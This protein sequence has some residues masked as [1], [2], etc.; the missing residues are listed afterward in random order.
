MKKRFSHFEMIAQRLV[1]GSFG[2]LFGE[3]L[4]PQDIGSRLA[5]AM[6]D[7][8]E[9]GQ[10]ADTYRIMLNPADQQSL[11]RRDPELAK[12]LSAYLVQLAQQAN[13]TLLQQPTVELIPDPML[14]RQAIRVETEQSHATGGSTQYQPRN[15]DDQALNLLK[16]VD[17]FLIVEGK[18]HVPLN[19]PIMTV[20]RRTDNDIVVNNAAVSRQH[21]QIRWRYGRFVI[22]DLGSRGG[23]AVNGQTI[24]E[25]VL[26]A[27]D[28]ITLS[29]VPLI[30]GEEV[31]RSEEVR[32]PADPGGQ[33]ET[34]IT[35]PR[36][37]V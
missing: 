29:G 13:L 18:R 37:E 27:G 30:Y 33:N 20:G 17:A 36:D 26:H 34:T 6:E 15:G 35:L 19:Q 3:S 4:Q 21:A 24:T 5:K 8:E 31:A 1:E 9:G 16:A 23:T 14:G 22:Y 25:S 11:C 32:R 12:Q 7:S 28:V 2:R 10:V